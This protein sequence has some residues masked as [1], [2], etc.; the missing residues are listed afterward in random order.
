V[1]QVRALTWAQGG[2]RSS[3]LLR[4]L[5]QWDGVHGS[6]LQ[7]HIP[8]GIQSLVSTALDQV[9]A[10]CQSDIGSMYCTICNI[11]QKMSFCCM[12]TEE[13]ENNTE[14]TYGDC[15]RT[16]VAFNAL[17]RM[18]VAGVTIFEKFYSVGST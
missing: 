15:S 4:H 1:D 12:A 2:A 6:P 17:A 7:D 9:A 16:V 11:A 5:G 3:S 13:R 10:L 14:G 18:N 8:D